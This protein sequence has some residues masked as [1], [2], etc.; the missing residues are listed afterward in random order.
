MLSKLR[1]YVLAAEDDLM[2]PLIPAADDKMDVTVL[3]VLV[4]RA[5]PKK[6]NTPCHVR[7]VAQVISPRLRAGTAQA[8]RATPRCGSGGVCL[9]RWR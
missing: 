8:S 5:E 7:F 1:G 9:A 2:A 4:D 3:G 6:A